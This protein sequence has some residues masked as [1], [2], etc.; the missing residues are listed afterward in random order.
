[1]IQIYKVSGDFFPLSVP[2]TREK[3]KLRTK[4]KKWEGEVAKS[5]YISSKNYYDNN[6]KVGVLDGVLALPTSFSKGKRVAHARAYFTYGT[7]VK[8]WKYYEEPESARDHAKKLNKEQGAICKVY[9]VDVLIKHPEQLRRF[10]LNIK[11]E[12]HCATAEH[13]YVLLQQV[14]AKTCRNRNNET[15]VPT[16]QVIL[17]KRKCSLEKLDRGPPQTPA[18]FRCACIQSCA[19]ELKAEISSVYKEDNENVSDDSFDEEDMVEFADITLF[20]QS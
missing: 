18:S 6:K 14:R 3:L 15:L 1:N 19:P 12:K 17:Q 2:E 8:T 16:T 7:G 20:V 13:A 10:G 4:R 11:Q 9:R 5:Q